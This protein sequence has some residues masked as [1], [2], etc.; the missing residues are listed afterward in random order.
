MQGYCQGLTAYIYAEHR[1]VLQSQ[2][3]AFDRQR[4]DLSPLTTL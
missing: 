1:E 3:V 4:Q 2:K